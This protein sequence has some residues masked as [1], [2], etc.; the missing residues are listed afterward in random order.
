MSENIKEVIPI[1]I[2]IRICEKDDKP[3]IELRKIIND[4]N[5]IKSILSCAFHN[6]PIILQPTFSDKL[7]AIS[8]LQE[9]GIIYKNNED[10][11]YYFTF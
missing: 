6:Q 4:M 2:Y 1:P 3:V 9:K 7:R 5:F 8:S 11:K 10:Q